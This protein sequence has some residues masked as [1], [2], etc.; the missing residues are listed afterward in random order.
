MF[1]KALISVYDKTG[2]TE[3]AEELIN[4]NC[5]IL[6]TGGTA[7]LLEEHHFKVQKISQ[8]T[9]FQEILD[10][11][12]KTLHPKIY[13]GILADRQKD[14]HRKEIRDLGYDYI[15]IVV[16]NLY[17]FEDVTSDINVKL[18]DA[19][20]NIDI[21]GVTLLRAAAKNFKNVL[22]LSDPKDYKPIL[23]RIK[24]FNEVDLK[25]RKTLAVKAFKRTL[26][27]DKAIAT[28]LNKVEIR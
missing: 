1:E 4:L 27:Y 16:V 7:R 15:D 18:G 22:V 24:K 14:E 21:G 19:I 11:R 17:P 20:E 12:V 3:L 26:L 25:T 8:F 23:N 5:E 2:I 28:Y 13:A 9:G 10:G 6:S